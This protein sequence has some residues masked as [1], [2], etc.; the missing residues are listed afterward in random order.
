MKIKD[1]AKEPKA[2]SLDSI[3]M[4]TVF[5]HGDN[6]Y[7][8]TDSEG[9]NDTMYVL[10]MKTGRLTQMHFNLVVQPLTAH[11]VIEREKQT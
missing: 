6:Y 11:L 9:R 2:C 1:K 8:K 7:C 4:G 3:N 10:N 5:L